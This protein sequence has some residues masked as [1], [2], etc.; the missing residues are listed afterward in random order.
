MDAQAY[1]FQDYFKGKG[2]HASWEGLSDLAPNIPLYRCLKKQFMEFVRPP[3]QGTSH[4]APDV[5]SL[6]YRVCDKAQE[7]NLHIFKAGRQDTSGFRATDILAEGAHEL[8]KKGMRLF[9]KQNKVCV[10]DSTPYTYDIGTDAYN[11]DSDSSDN[12]E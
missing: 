12:E 9:A 8:Q 10:R 1:N 11:N 7:L 6:I 5:S 2:M 4:S 3:H